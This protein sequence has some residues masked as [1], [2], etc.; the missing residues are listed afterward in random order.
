MK[1]E[2]A[3]QGANR[4]MLLALSLASMALIVSRSSFVSSFG[5]LPDDQRFERIKASPNYVNGEFSYYLPTALW[6]GG[7]SS[8]YLKEMFFGPHKQVKPEHPLPVLKTDLAALDR[9]RDL[10]VWLGHSSYFIQLGGKRILID[11]VLSS[12][13]S[14]VP[15]LNPTPPQTY[16]RLTTW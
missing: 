10:V 16:P 6:T 8:S 1:F 11:P 3:W 4:W 12:Y 5:R 15:F 7:G 13:A 14:P 9:N 2:N